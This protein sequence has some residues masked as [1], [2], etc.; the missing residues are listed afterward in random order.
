MITSRNWKALFPAFLLFFPAA[1]A[2][3]YSKDLSD[4]TVKFVRNMKLIESRTPEPEIKE[5]IK[6]VYLQSEKVA[7][8]FRNKNADTLRRKIRQY[9]EE[10]KLD[11]D[12]DER[13][14]KD[15]R[16]M[17]EKLREKDDEGFFKAAAARYRTSSNELRKTL[18]LVQT[19]DED[20]AQ[21]IRITIEHLS[22]YQEAI[23]IYPN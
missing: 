7:E 22:L 11:P 18:N 21:L 16:E 1:N 4:I 5:M 6:V 23:S 20:R 9:E 12:I 14:V 3:D 8:A 15:L 2:Q 10:R 19:N 13:H 17:R